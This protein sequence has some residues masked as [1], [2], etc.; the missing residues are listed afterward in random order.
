MP[1][2]FVG[3]SS[4]DSAP[5]SMNVY[6]S[7]EGGETAVAPAAATAPEGGDRVMAEAGAEA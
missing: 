1:V 6:I 3:V 4:P 2:M 7:A 5:P